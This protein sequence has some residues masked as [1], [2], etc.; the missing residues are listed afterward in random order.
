MVNKKLRIKLWV[1]LLG[2]WIIFIMFINNLHII[3]FNNL[4]SSNKYKFAHQSEGYFIKEA[5]SSSGS[6]YVVNWCRIWRNSNNDKAYDIEIDNINNFIYLV[7]ETNNSGTGMDIIILKYDIRG[8]LIWNKTWTGPNLNIDGALDMELDLINN[9]LFIVGITRS[10]GAGGQDIILL[11]YYTNGTL[12]WYRT[13]GGINNDRGFGIDFDDNNKIIYICGDT[14]SFGAGGK[15]AV[16]LKYDENGTLIQN[17][18]WGGIGFDSIYDLKIDFSNNCIFATGRTHSLVDPSGDWLLLKFDMNCNLLWAKSGGYD[19]YDCASGLTLDN[20]NYLYI[21]GVTKNYKIGRPYTDLFLAKYDITG[22]LIW[23][24]T[25]GDCDHDDGISNSGIEF[26]SNDNCIYL[27]G[28]SGSYITKGFSDII[29]TKYAT[30]GSIIDYEFWGSSGV[31]KGGGIAIDYDDNKIYITGWTTNHTTQDINIVLLEYILDSDN[32]GLSD[33]DEVNIYN[34]NPNNSDSDMDNI[35]DGDEIIIY[36]TN[37]LI[38]DTDNDSFLDGDEV[39]NRYNPNDPKN[40]DIYLPTKLTYDLSSDHDPAI[41]TNPSNTFFIIA[42]TSNRNPAKWNDWNIWYKTSEDGIIWSEEKQL[43]WDIGW[44]YRPSIGIDSGNN[45]YIFWTSNRSGNWDIWFKKSTD[46]GNTWTVPIQVTNHTTYDRYPD[47]F[48]DENDIIHLFWS[49]GS[50]L[51]DGGVGYKNSTDG[52]VWSDTIVLKDMIHLPSVYYNKYGIGYLVT[53]QGGPFEDIWIKNVSFN[54]FNNTATKI[55]EDDLKDYDPCVVVDKA[56]N[57][58]IFWQSTRENDWQIWYKLK[59]YNSEN[60]TNP[61]KL[62]NISSIND[63]IEYGDI[64]AGY[65]DAIL[66]NNDNLYLVY[67]KRYHENNSIRYMGTAY[68]DPN[69]DHYANKYLMIPEDDYTIETGDT[70]CYDIFFPEYSE[71]FSS[72]AMI[73]FTDGTKLITGVPDQNGIDMHPDNNIEYYAKEKW[74]HREFIIPDEHIGKNISSFTMCLV[75]ENGTT[76]FFLKNIMIKNGNEIKLTAYSNDS[77]HTFPEGYYS[78]SDNYHNLTYEVV[79]N[80]D[81]WFVFIPNVTID[82]DGDGLIGID[83][84]YYQTSYNNND[85]DGDGLNDG[86]EVN[87]YGTNPL[88]IDSDNDLMP[89]KWEIEYNLNPLSNDAFNDEDYDGVNNLNEF[90]NNTNPLIKDTD[91]DGVYDYDEILLYST[92]PTNN[93]TDSDNLI[94][95]KEIYVYNTDPLKNDTDN[96]LIRYR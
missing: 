40:P 68:P 82:I 85:T 65:V 32:D 16:I 87:I 37:P 7:G 54:N 28:Y 96:D 33:Y 61:R 22:N 62:T 71:K 23:N 26:N 86:D 38:N 60:W 56:N 39:L 35:N 12:I 52:I 79:I 77:S 25:W 49:I 73:C 89:D 44:D 88:N 19:D 8:N 72:G 84:Y 21:S 95:Y 42:W 47:V 48:I 45:I 80:R 53:H 30:N 27:V 43:T 6:G 13:W 81:I 67:V 31:D 74:Y 64:T 58:L 46:F 78:K 15:D 94:D 51:P 2:L 29:F 14:E 59:Q 1:I 11:K 55:T 66:D 93:D 34:T 91:Y 17:N 90:R 83:E 92:D 41:A 3:N 69:N 75:P 18:T 76:E 50:S 9:Y 4:D 5:S 10:I 24:Y 63:T 70:F 36:N 20:N 57:T